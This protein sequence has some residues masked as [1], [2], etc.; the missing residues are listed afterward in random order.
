MNWN[1]SEVASANPVEPDHFVFME[2]GSVHGLRGRAVN[3]SRKM[4]S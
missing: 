4:N 3:N 2:N 1:L